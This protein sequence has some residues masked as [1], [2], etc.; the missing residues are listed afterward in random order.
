MTIKLADLMR[1]LHPL[2]PS[3]ADLPI[4]RVQDDSRKIAPGDLFVAVPGLTVNGERFAA[5]AVAAGAVAVVAQEPLS[6]GVPC[7]VVP[8]PIRVLG[9]V[10]ARLAGEPAR[11]LKLLGITGTNGKTTTTYL[12]EAMLS[13]AGQRP[14]VIGTIT[15]RYAGHSE[16]APYT[17]PTALL[18]QQILRQM[19][20][21]NCTHVV[22]EVSSHALQL[23]RAWGLDFSVAAFTHLTQ[24]H[25]D[26]HGSMEAYL[27]AKLLLFSRHLGS[28]GTAVVNADGGGAEA[29]I[30]VAR[31][32]T[33]VRLLRC[34]STGRPAEMTLH[35]ID[36]SIQGITAT[37]VAPD[38][39]TV[40]LRSPLLGAYNADNILM[41]AT[42]CYAAGVDLAAIARG[43]S[44]L[45]GVPGRLERVAHAGDLPVLVDYAHTP[46]ALE[47]ALAVL[48]PLCS[49]RLLVVFGC[50][51][52][53][54]RGKRPLMGRAV[55][56]GAD[57]A[58]VTSDNPR[59]EEPASIIEAIVEGVQAEAMP[60]LTE[61]GGARGFIVQPDRRQAIQAAVWAARPGDVVLI[62][63]KGHEDY[64]ILG[65]KK[66]H[67]D[68][69]EEAREALAQL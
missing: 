1:D 51:G 59:T 33:D 50:G 15:Y 34:S 3:W 52:D 14:G 25:L 68:D 30:E 67:F 16:P 17:T 63:G 12:M 47:R 8:D 39:S 13:A 9:H 20:E 66:I 19:A 26:L 27:Q 11:R 61:L 32:R 42:C 6:L 37:L 22:A 4:L 29:V 31:R 24:D 60:Q 10:A 58:V 2:E 40:A 65:H 48:R 44:A 7:L 46:D 62:A 36:F 35:Q 18:L 5:A 41:A 53:R 21:G 28:G 23:G 69:R 55:A 64:Q 49:G 54:D 57:L 45:T 43:V 38:G 56:H